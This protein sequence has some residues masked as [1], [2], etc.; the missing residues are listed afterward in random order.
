MVVGIEL[1]TIHHIEHTD[2]H[3]DT[4]G[5]G[6]SLGS[7]HWP[8][9]DITQLD[10]GPGRIEN[11][12]VGTDTHL[13]AIGTCRKDIELTLPTERTIRYNPIDRTQLDV[14]IYTVGIS[15]QPEIGRAARQGERGRLTASSVENGRSQLQLQLE[16]IGR[17][18][19]ASVNFNA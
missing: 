7:I 2:E 14:A 4:F 17:V 19:N 16:I 8:S 1:A 9:L 11:A 13:Y 6:S 5:I 15:Q 18:K 12:L 3:I 10:I